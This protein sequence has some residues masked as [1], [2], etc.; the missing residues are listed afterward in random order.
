MLIICSRC[1]NIVNI[2]CENYTKDFANVNTKY[3]LS[4][5]SGFQ[6]FVQYTQLLGSLI[7]QYDLT[8][9]FKVL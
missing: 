9:C 7:V 8:N 2:T 5:I 1:S 6:I 3:D 4:I